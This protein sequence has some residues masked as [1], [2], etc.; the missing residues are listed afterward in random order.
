MGT[1]TKR[2]KRDG[3]LSYTAQIRIKKGGVTVHTEARTFETRPAARNWMHDREAKLRM[4]G[5]LARVQHRGI[6]IGKLLRD[7]KSEVEAIK[8]LGRT[9]GQHLAFLMRHDLSQEDAITITAERLIEHVRARR[10]AGT[11]PATVGNDLIWLRI[12]FSYAMHAWG[13]PVRIEPI[14][15]AAK[16]ARAAGLIAK[17]NRRMRRVSDAEI[18][19]VLA[20]CGKKW[21]TYPMADIVMFALHS[22]RRQAEITRIRWTDLDD[23]THTGIVRDVKHPSKKAGNH[24]RCKFPPEAWKIIERQPR[25]GALVFPYDSKTVG[26]YFTQAV[27]LAGIEDLHF[28][29]LRHEATSRLFERGHSIQEVQLITLHESWQE[30]R[31]YTHLRAE[32]VPDR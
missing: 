13:T 28:H 5:E 8:P 31:R 16:L 4:P 3:T 18:A 27:K 19:S 17:A 26:A 12:V 14:D 24:R 21:S 22:A 23:A 2:K 29:D 15:T 1:I 9:K 30:L 10:K 32:D 25:D 6:T 7:Y 11:G 20:Q